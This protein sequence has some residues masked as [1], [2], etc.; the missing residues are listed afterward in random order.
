MTYEVI[1]SGEN[2]I[3]ASYKWHPLWLARPVT[4]EA[5]ALYN[6]WFTKKSDADAYVAKMNGTEGR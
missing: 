5:P 4:C 2:F 1:K 6:K 3:D